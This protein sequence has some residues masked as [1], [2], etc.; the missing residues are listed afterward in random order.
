MSTFTAVIYREG[1]LYIAECKELGTVSQGKDTEEALANL[2]E[3]TALY[4]EEFPEKKPTP[5]FFTTFTMAH[6]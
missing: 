1:N 4:L 2:Q 5:M 6:A 3:A